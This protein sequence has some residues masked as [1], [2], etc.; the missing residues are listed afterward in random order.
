MLRKPARRAAAME[1]N[2]LSEAV[3][4]SKETGQQ[5]I[6]LSMALFAVLLATATM[7]SHRAHTEE[8]L[9]ETQVTDQ[10]AYY[11]AKDIRSHVFD[12]DAGLAAMFGE[13]G[14]KLAADFKNQSVKQRS[15]AE[16]I[17]V[18]AEDKEKEVVA[19]SRKAKYYDASELLMEVAIVLC[20][21]SL[22]SRSRLYWKSSFVFVGL[23]LAVVVY[24]LLLTAH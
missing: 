21:I 5:L 2:E 1:V 23:G 18:I 7:L 14:E 4:K 11:Q 15:D 9:I 6:G 8:V 12:A 17:R 24:G 13:K 22:L 20:S 19:T 16:K 10:W 3:E